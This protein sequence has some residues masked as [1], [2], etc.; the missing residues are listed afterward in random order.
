[1]TEIEA[2]GLV[3]AS[4]EAVFVF[5]SAL[6]NH[7]TVAG[8]WVQLV[9][10]DPDAEGGRVRIH[11]PVGM[12]RTATTRVHATDPPRSIRGSARLGATCAQV[13][14]TLLARGAGSTEVRLA[15]VVVR[16]GR[17]DRA[18]LALGG[19]RWM[20]RLF[21]ITLARLAAE[22]PAHAPIGELPAL[23]AIR[24]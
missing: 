4:A 11:G 10:L 12:R 23:S 20:R 7:W 14:W 22:V 3:P 1:M 24:A 2:T 18:L 6:E 17:L 21:T 15:A 5:L 8:R 9:R 13:S 16:A 19:A